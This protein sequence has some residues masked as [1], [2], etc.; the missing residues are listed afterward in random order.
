MSSVLLRQENG[1]A[2]G[3]ESRGVRRTMLEEPVQ[4]R[5]DKFLAGVERRAFRMAQIA[6]GQRE[7]ALDIVQEAMVKLVSKYAARPEAEWGPLFQTI[8]Q[9][10]I[11][12]HYRRSQIRSRLFGWLD[13]S[14]EVA[15]AQ[16]ENLR[17]PEPSR[18]LASSGASAAICAA[19]GE[20]PLRQQ[21]AFM[22]RAWEGLDTAQTA[23]AMGC[24]AG[25][26]K[27]HYA[28]ALARLREKLEDHHEGR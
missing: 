8:L 28:R 18:A 20:L 15:I 14:G 6:V 22:L 12:D 26:V 19:L 21:Q 5:L 4:Q 2:E 17:E 27:T 16:A 10:K 9:S 25:S 1:E 13:G 23:R 11:R 3:W 24:S 7:D